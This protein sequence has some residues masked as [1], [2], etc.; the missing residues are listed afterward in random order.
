MQAGGI[1]I[2]SLSK[3][4]IT[5]PYALPVGL[6]SPIRS[7]LPDKYR[8]EP[9]GHLTAL[10]NQKRSSPASPTQSVALSLDGDSEIKPTADQ[11]QLLGTYR[12]G[13]APLDLAALQERWEEA[14]HGLAVEQLGRDERK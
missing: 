8:H 12:S 1:G 10:V 6:P 14:G 7:K 9:R 3:H 11:K 5:F 13:W 4:S 2:H